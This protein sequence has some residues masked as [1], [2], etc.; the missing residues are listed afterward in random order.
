MLWKRAITEEAPLGLLDSSN[1]EP[2]SKALRWVVSGIA[3]LVLLSLSL[4]YT[5]RFYPERRAAERFLDALVAGDT[6]RAYQIWNPQPS[7]TYKDF[8]DDWGP[9]G[10]YGPVKSYRIETMQSP[11]GGG[12]GVVVVAGISPVQP[13]PQEN[14]VESRRTKEVKIWVEFRDK[15]LGFPP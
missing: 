12:S 7:Y 10:Y 3:L 14:T 11:R 9:T 4:W 6:Q 8:L 13:F 15:S 2:K 1:E 5:F